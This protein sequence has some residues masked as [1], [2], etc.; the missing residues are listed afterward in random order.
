MGHQSCRMSPASLSTTSSASSLSPSSM[1]KG[2]NEVFTAG[3]RVLYQQLPHAPYH[4]LPPAPSNRIYKHYQQQKVVSVPANCAVAKRRG[5][6]K[7]SQ[8]DP[9]FYTIPLNILLSGEV[10]YVCRD[11]QFST[12]SYRTVQQHESTSGHRRW[13]N[14]PQET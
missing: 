8:C 7:C 12:P 13:Y 3:A 2:T 1:Q 14:Y 6:C 11:C 5:P 4:Q 9:N 10:E